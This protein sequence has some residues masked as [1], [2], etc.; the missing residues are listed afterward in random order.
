M[1]ALSTSCELWLKPYDIVYSGYTGI[2]E[3]SMG[4]TIVYWGYTGM[5]KMETTI[6]NS[7][8]LDQ[9]QCMLLTRAI[10]S[11]KLTW[12]PKKGP[13]RLQSF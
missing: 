5:M 4:T 8:D 6:G 3:K 9:G 11:R 7:G 10:H 2:M 1:S 13:I 12:K